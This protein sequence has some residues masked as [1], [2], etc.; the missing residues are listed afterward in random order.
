MLSDDMDMVGADAGP[1]ARASM[2]E[3]QRVCLEPLQVE[4][5]GEMALVLDDPD[6]HRFTGGSPA[7]RAELAKTYS[8]Q[9]AGPADRSQRWLNWI[10]RRL[11]DDQAVG[12][13]Q[14]TIGRKEG[15]VVAEVAWIVGTAYQGHGYAT[16]AAEV[17]VR[18]IRSQGDVRI[19]AHVHPDNTPSAYVAR[20]VGLSPTDVVVDGEVRWL[21]G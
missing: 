12:T 5:A 7:T 17:M 21:G 13:V 18:W 1:W 10:V 4:H 3:G 15:R 8:R 11:A 6:L 19:V 2:L 14:A 20:A 16:E 9:V